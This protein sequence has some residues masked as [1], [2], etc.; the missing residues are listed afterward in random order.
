MTES[1]VDTK[2]TKGVQVDS[3]I[4]VTIFDQFKQKVGTAERLY[5]G[6]STTME[7]SIPA[8]VF[9]LA[10]GGGAILFLL[11]VFILFKV[12]SL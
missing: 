9:L 12:I 3:V 2:D 5:F 4:S 11:V 8:Y 1:I 10:G 6:G 7:K